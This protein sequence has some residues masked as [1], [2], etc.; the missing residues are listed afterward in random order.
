MIK[1]INKCQQT[2]KKTKT[3]TI[4]YQ[5]LRLDYPSIN[6]Y[7]LYISFGSLGLQSMLIFKIIIYK[8]LYKS[9][10]FLNQHFYLNNY[11][12]IK[13]NW[14]KS[15][16]PPSTASLHILPNPPWLIDP[17]M[18]TATKPN[19]ITTVWMTSVHITAFNPP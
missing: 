10:I 9:K 14:L 11:L 19:I 6:I 8:S 17:W 5:F 16:L 13:T 2:E 18:I 7:Y 4:N 3:K 15:I 12:I 1:S